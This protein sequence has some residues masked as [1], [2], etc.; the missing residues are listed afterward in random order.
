M[1][2]LRAML[3][4]LNGL[5][6]RKRREQELAAE[7]ASHLQMHI[8]DNLR[9]GMSPEMARR[10]AL[11]KLGGLEQAKELYRDRRGLPYLENLLQDLR[12]AFRVLR[13]NP[14]FTA[15]AILTLALGI[16][17]TTAIFSVV[18][19]VLLRPLPYAD[20]NRI[21][22]IFEVNSKGTWSSLAEPNF[23]DF[24]DQNRSFQ[25]IA[26]YNDDVV[27]ISGASQPTRTAVAHIS[28]DF[29]KVFGIQLILGRD[30]SASDAKKGAGPTV[31]VSYGYWRQH[32]GSPGDLSQSHLKIG[33]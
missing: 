31:L 4:R 8:E 17:A 32:L 9:A 3:L 12:F 10:E 22:A 1:R 21:M 6:S 28:P 29:L 2:R 19:G 24:R 30:F 20:S 23:D 33:G 25:A 14:G 5:F 16:G 27:S 7:M 13:K 18:Y 11:M 15:V 26:K